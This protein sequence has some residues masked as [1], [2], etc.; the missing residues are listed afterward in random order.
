MKKKRVTKMRAKR[1]KRSIPDR[2]RPL[3]LYVWED[4]LTEVTSGIAF[5]LATN[6]RQAR[7]KILEAYRW[8]APVT[9]PISY[10]TLEKELAAKPKVLCTAAGFAL[11]GEGG[12]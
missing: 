5:A 1:V 6:V 7:K 4:V 8:R 3:R 9:G 12:K 10:G 2:T 11:H